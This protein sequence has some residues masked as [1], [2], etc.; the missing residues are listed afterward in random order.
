VVFH[1]QADRQTVT[2][3]S[4]T[5]KIGMRQLLHIFI[6]FNVRLSRVIDRWF[7]QFVEA[8]SYKDQL[9]HCAYNVINERG[10]CSVLEVGGIDR[11]L[12]QRSETI[13]YDGLDIEYKP[14]CENIYDNFFVQSIEKPVKYKYDMVISMALLEH[15]RDNDASVTQMYEALKPSGYAIHYLPSKYHPYAIILR[16]VSPKWQVRLIKTLRP[17]AV[18]TTGYPAFFDRSSPMEMRT[19]FNCKGFQS[20]ETMSFFRANDYFRFFVPL[21]MGVSLWEN[22][23]N[24][25]KW[26]QLCS[27]FIIIA[28]K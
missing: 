27:G 14:Q 26:E 8:K 3:V 23:C 16:L 22:I 25:F 1:I 4:K 2:T 21:Y 19:L 28:Q 18:E 20:V 13:R 10:A 24:K 12:L 11:P 9:L 5:L 15:V 7:P 6:S 17:W